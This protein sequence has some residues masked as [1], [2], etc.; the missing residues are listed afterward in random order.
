M[1]AGL[2]WFLTKGIALTADLRGVVAVNG[3][4]VNEATSTRV[5]GYDPYWFQGTLGVRLILPEKE[6]RVCGGRGTALRSLHP[7]I[8]AAGADGFM[9]GNYLT[10]AGL[11]PRED[12]KMISD[13]G[14]R[15]S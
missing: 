13:L 8:F 10:Q 9:I 7:L 4:V 3:D 1:N 11:D 15:I 14:L 12:L 6:I 5:T 2:D